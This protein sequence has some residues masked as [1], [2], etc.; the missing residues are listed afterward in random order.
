MEPNDGI[1]EYL[2]LIHAIQQGEETE[3]VNRD[4]M[5]SI[6]EGKAWKLRSERALPRT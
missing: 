2:A 5:F 3:P 4:E 1:M 6:L